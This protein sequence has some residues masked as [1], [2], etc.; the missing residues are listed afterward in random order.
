MTIA[1]APEPPS[2]VRPPP[3]REP[4]E[5]ARPLPEGG[6]I[7]ARLPPYVNPNLVEEGRRLEAMR[8]QWARR[9]WA[10]WSLLA[11]NLLMFLLE[12]ALGGSEVS[13]VLV[14]LGGLVPEL[15]LE[16]EWW[17]LVSAGFL[18]AGFLHVALNS[19]VLYIVGPTLERILGPTRFLVAYTF[20][21]LVASFASLALSHAQLTVG[22]SG[23][24][25]GLF[26]VEAIVVFLRPQLLPT[27]LR[28]RHAKTVLF[29]LFINVAASFQP[30]IA[31]MAHFGGALGGAIAGF[32]LVPHRF[33]LEPK[34][35][36]LT[37]I[38]AGLSVLL[39]AAGVGRALLFTLE[40][41]ALLSHT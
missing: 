13:V 37:T 22:A 8:A 4:L 35:S 16:G 3:P 28:K 29:N 40:H 26:G 41:V 11:V 25:F 31:T 39:L 33:T 6:S 38:L 14:L 9:P 30:N 17:R 15:V 12:E 27:E 34:R 23:A 32:F 7:E 21:L 18:H 24:I 5:R 1:P 19:Y 36:H 10:T 2:A 20:S